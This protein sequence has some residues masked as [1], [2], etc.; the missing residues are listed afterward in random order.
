[1][2]ITGATGFAGS[3]L[4]EEYCARGWEVWGTTRG[5]ERDLDWLPE[6]VRLREVELLDGRG[7]D[8]LLAEA[9]PDV[10]QH[11]AA[12]SSVSASWRDP[13]GTLQDNARAQFNVLEAAIRHA[14]G[15][16]ALV[17]G[18]ADEYGNVSPEENPV[19]EDHPLKPANPYALSKVVQDLM[20]LQYEHREVEV[21]R[22]RPFLQLGPRRPGT[23]VAGSFARQVAEIEAG[24]RE[25]VI[26]VGN[27]GLARDFTDV[28]DVARAFFLLGE[29]GVEGTVYNV[30]S[31]V[32]RTLRDLLDGMLAEA[33]ISVRIVPD[34][35]LFRGD[36]PPL[37]VGDA[38]RLRVATGW[39]PRVSFSQSVRDT[40]QDWR[41]RVSRTP[42]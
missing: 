11:L 34:P 35:A 10:V 26:R 1:M 20:S 22:V 29:H 23:F 15:C 8:R 36:E 30:A 41:A 32:A 5:L 38:T 25:A 16:R 39:E 42:V 40:L 7:V 37:L 4:V 13:M 17:V 28:R 2:L 27:I 12:H 19:T 6:D 21:I 18:S 31:G 33:G 3:F 14:P 24:R 9:R